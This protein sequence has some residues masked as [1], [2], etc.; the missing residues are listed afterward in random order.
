MN[1]RIAKKI[2]KVARKLPASVVVVNKTI[3]KKKSELPPK[4]QERVAHLP[5]EYVRHKGQFL[6]DI[7]H[8]KMLR[9]YYEKHG[10]E[11]FLDKYMEWFVPHHTK[12]QETYP[13]LMEPEPENA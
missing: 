1:G 5:G 3:T 11:L 10:G 2:R 8:V 7:D 4:E 6:E 12:M 9:Q 13:H